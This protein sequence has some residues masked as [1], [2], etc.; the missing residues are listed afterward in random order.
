MLAGGRP[1]R[2]SLGKGENIESP[3][4]SFHDIWDFLDSISASGKD[5]S[6][7]FPEGLVQGWFG[8][9]SYESGRREAASA[10]RLGED[11]DFYFFKP[12]KLWMMDRLK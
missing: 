9:F 6:T 8:A 2:G 5:S 11:P 12:K 3:A 10:V 1:L 4:S 7:V